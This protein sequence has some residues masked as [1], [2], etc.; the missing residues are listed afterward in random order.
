MLAAV[1]EDV[2]RMTLREVP[3]PVPGP[4]EVVVAMRACGICQTDFTAYTGRRMN[5]RKGMIVG[6]EMAGVVDALGPGVGDLRPGEPVAVCPAVSCGLCRWCR[7][8]LQHYCPEGFAIGGEGFDRVWDG[9]FAEKVKAPRSAV[10]RVPQGIPLASACLTEPLA[11][12]YKGM[13]EY[14]QLRLG[15]DVVIIG[16]GGMGLLLCQVA[17]AAGAGKLVL[18]DIE[19]FKLRIAEACGATHTVDAR[20]ADPYDAIRAILPDGPDLVFEA[21]GVLE[22]AAL[23]Y[24]LCRRGTRINMFG[25][26]V[27]GTIEVDPAHIHFT[28]IRMDASF[29]VTPRVMVRSLELQAKRLVD[30]ARI[31]THRIPLERIGEALQVMET[32]ERVKVVVTM[33]GAP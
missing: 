23:A 6:H 14:S 15:E 30:P 22:A 19:P 5:W 17:K 20:A 13:I 16:A 21:A 12:S 3:D 33:G 7:L 32:P 25:V 8:G 2:R 4:G 27:P 24:R 9:G 28:E 11:G 31:V 26:I 10:Y 18:V 29:S 1:L